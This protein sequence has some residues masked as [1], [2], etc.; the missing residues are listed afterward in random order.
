MKMANRNNYDIYTG[1]LIG[2]GKLESNFAGFLGP[3]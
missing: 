3:N 1:L 2:H